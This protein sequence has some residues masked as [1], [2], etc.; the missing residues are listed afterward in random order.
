MAQHF[1]TV[2]RHDQ[3]MIR[4]YEPGEARISVA[5]LA[6]AGRDDKMTSVAGV[7]DWADYTSKFVAIEWLDG[8]HYSFLGQP[9]QVAQYVEQF[10]KTVES[11]TLVN[12]R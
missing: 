6:L 1:L 4:D 3:A 10:G 8:Q 7:A 12:S 9:N 11:S 2:L 5:I